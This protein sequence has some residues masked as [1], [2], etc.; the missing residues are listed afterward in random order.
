MELSI[1]ASSSSGNCALLT[2]E[3]T[4]LLIDAG[5]S[6]SKIKAAM[7]QVHRSP[8]DLDG[9]L[10]T[11]EHSDHT[12]GVKM[13]LKRAGVTVYAP[14]LVAEHLREQLPEYGEQIETIDLQEPFAL[15]DVSVTAFPTPHDVPQSAGYRVETAEACFCLCTDLGHVT[16]EVLDDLLGADLALIESNHDVEM[17][18]NGPYPWLLKQRILSDYGHLSND[19]CA[20][21]AVTLAEHG[22][23]QL[24]LGHLSKENNTPRR[25]LETVSQA[26]NRA[27]YERMFLQVAPVEGLL[28]VPVKGKVVC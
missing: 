5:I 8:E 11:H 3:E 17:V 9:V 21:L 1:F 24:V 10:I 4:N 6:F 20:R 28:R 13:L 22:T 16:D 18:K 2:A 7:E 25:A 27:G 12:K 19:T 14:P 15:G 26:L 23:R